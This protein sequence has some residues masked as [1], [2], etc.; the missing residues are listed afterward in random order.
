ML[1]YIRLLHGSYAARRNIS[2][3]HTIGLVYMVFVDLCVPYLCISINAEKRIPE[4]VPSANVASSMKKSCSFR[5]LPVQSCSS[6]RFVVS[7]LFWSST[8]NQADPK[9]ITLLLFFQISFHSLDYIC[10]TSSFFDSE[11]SVNNVIS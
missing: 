10:D 7:L 2:G 6:A 4:L 3:R 8:F 1:C 11:E 9:I 5:C